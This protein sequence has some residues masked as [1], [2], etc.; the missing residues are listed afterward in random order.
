MR[1]AGLT[2][3]CVLALCLGVLGGGGLLVGCVSTFAQPLV[4]KVSESF[5]EWV[6]AFQPAQL[7]QQMAKQR[8]LQK[9]MLDELAV[10][11]RPWKPY[12]IVNL[13]LLA[14]AVTGL[15][16]GAVKG[17]KLR[18]RADKWLMTGMI[19]G[20]LYSL[21][22]SYIAYGTARETQPIAAKYTNMT[23]QSVPAGSAPAARAASAAAMKVTAAFT[24]IMVFGWA[25]AKCTYYAIGIWYLRTPRIRQLFEGDGSERAVIDALSDTPT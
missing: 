9:G 11:Q 21:L 14:V 19:T 23:L 10:I 15:L 17:L 24:M 16:V 22:A 18:P 5:Q 1:P 13:L 12:Q 4:M 8:E 2:A 6:L 3:V 7:R 25:V 20:V